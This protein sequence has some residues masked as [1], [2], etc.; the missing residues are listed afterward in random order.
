MADFRPRDRSHGDGDERR[1]EGGGADAGD[2]GAQDAGQDGQPRDVARPSLIG[3]HAEGG[4]TLEMLHRR[5]ALAGGQCHVGRGDVVLEVDEPL[6]A[7]AEGQRDGPRGPDGGGLGDLDAG[8]RGRCL[9]IREAGGAG[10]LGAGIEALAQAAGKVERPLRRAGGAFGLHRRAGDEGGE[11]FVVDRAA[12]RLG[13]QVHGRVPAPGDAEQIT[14]DA[15]WGAGDGVAPITQAGDID[16]G[17]PPA[18]A[19][20]DDRVSADA[21]DAGAPGPGR[22]PAPVAPAQVDDGGYRDA[23]GG[24]VGRRFVS[25]IVVGEHHG[26]LTG[27]D[28]VPVGVGARRRG[29]HHAGPVVVGE[30]QGAFDGPGGDHDLAGAHDPHPLAGLERRW[31]KH[32]VG[33]P[34]GDRQGVVVVVA[35]HAGAPEHG[36]VRHGGELGHHG[37]H[38]RR[39]RRIV[40]DVVAGIQRAAERRAVVG[41]DDPSPRP[42][43]RQ[44]RR[45]PRRPAAGHQHVAMGVAVLVAVGVGVGRGLAHARR[46]ADEILEGHPAGPHEGLVVEARRQEGGKQRGQPVYVE[47]DRRPAV[48]AGGDEALEQL[49]LGGAD[50]GLGPRPGAQLDECVGLLHPAPEDAARPVV[51]EAA[52]EKADP[53]REQ[54]RGQGVARVTL[55]AAPVEG[56]AEGPRPVDA[57]AFRVA[58]GLAGHLRPSSGGSPGEVVASTSLVTVS[59]RTLI[60]CRQPP[61]CCQY[62]A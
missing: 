19:G 12:L 2:I 60:H 47:V 46:T 23:G 29:E 57:A 61:M 54:R 49:D 42:A 58:V 14:V 48:L 50:V 35:E 13:V 20:P 45:Q 1:A 16:P 27:A 28:R 21:F 38:P 10:R 31:L 5:V 4:V 11:P 43:R 55:E 36:H 59:R 52:G 17:E 44:R 7:A 39:C 41:Q 9:G 15:P 25:R 32:V 62:S 8:G 3:A 33:D 40:D 30:H 26:A 56:E 24:E 6:A 22:R 34:L 53:A 18:A 51:L 37:R